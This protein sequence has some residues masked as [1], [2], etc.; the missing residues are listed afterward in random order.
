VTVVGN[1]PPANVTINEMT[2]VASV[3]THN[4]F[5][6]GTT[7]KGS[8]LVLRIAAGNVPNFVD[9]ETGGYGPLPRTPPAGTGRTAGA[10]SR[11]GSYAIDAPSASNTL[12]PLRWHSQWPGCPG[13]RGASVQK[14]VK[15][16]TPE[17]RTAS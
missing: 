2:T 1:Q 11:H 7:I 15:R 17:G 12:P 5:I 13:M 8:P 9:L 4:Q 3:W 14:N 6:D 16:S 10:G